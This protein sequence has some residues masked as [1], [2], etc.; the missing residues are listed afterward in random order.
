[1]PIGHFELKPSKNAQFYFNLKASNGRIILTSEMYKTK[2]S[3]NKGITSVQTNSLD[4]AQYNL[5]P[6][7]SGHYYFVLKAKNHEIIGKSESYSSKSAAEK[8]IESVI[9]NGRTKIIK[10]FT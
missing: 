2:D 10:E 1:M 7:K 4:R 9:K 8:G 6:D 5:Q 3:V